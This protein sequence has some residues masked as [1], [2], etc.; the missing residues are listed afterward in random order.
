MC[1][2]DASGKPGEWQPVDSNAAD[3]DTGTL[4]YDVQADEEQLAIALQSLMD[5]GV[6][7][8]RFAEI[9]ADLEDVFMTL[10]R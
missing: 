3:G 1:Q 2:L 4:R 8:S 9:P 5:R 7:V 6:P 10:T